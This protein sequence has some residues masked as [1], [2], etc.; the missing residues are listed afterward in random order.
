MHILCNQCYRKSNVIHGSTSWRLT[1]LPL[2]GMG[3]PPVE[4]NRPCR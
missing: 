2:V 1:S 3:T 4:I